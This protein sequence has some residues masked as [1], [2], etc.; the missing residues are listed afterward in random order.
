MRIL[1]VITI[2]DHSTCLCHKACH[3]QFI[4]NLLLVYIVPL[5]L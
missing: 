4:W 3:G 1:I 5:T 2:S